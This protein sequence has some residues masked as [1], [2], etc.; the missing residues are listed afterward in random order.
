MAKQGLM[1]IALPERE[2]GRRAAV[3]AIGQVAAVC[4]AQ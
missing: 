1:D 4:P 3:I 2:V